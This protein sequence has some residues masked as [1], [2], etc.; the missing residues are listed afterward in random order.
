[1]NLGFSV[2]VLRARDIETT[3]NFYRALGLEFTSEQHGQGPLHFACERDDFVL[4]IYPLKASQSEVNDSVMLGFRVE[5]LE[6]AL[7]KL[8]LDAEIKMGDGRSCIVRDPDGRAVRLS[9]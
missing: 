9:E 1:M 3:A 6:L 7:Q 5:S 2:L 8:S 4:E